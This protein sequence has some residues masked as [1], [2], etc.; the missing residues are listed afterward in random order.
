MCLRIATQI[1]K[2]TWSLLIYKFLQIYK[3]CISISYTSCG[4]CMVAAEII[5]SYGI[6]LLNVRNTDC[7]YLFKQYYCMYSVL[8]ICPRLA[9]RNCFLRRCSRSRRPDYVVNVLGDNKSS[10]LRTVCSVVRSLLS[11]CEVSFLS[12]ILYLL[13][14]H[15]ICKNENFFCLLYGKK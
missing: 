10:G 2:I 8:S 14:V 11:H 7:L 15:I 13:T 5:Y 4:I 6:T 12:M 9:R 1:C 3:I